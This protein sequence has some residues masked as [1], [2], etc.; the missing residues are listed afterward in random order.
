MVVNDVYTAL[1]LWQR[2]RCFIIQLGTSIDAPPK[3]ISIATDV[4]LVWMTP[5][6][7][8]TV[9]L[10]W[11]SG[12][13]ASMGPGLARGLG[14]GVSEESFSILLKTLREVENLC[15]K[16]SKCGLLH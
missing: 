15:L 2:S 16:G 13:R 9:R 11:F 12:E 14:R 8:P 1:C 10:P 6:P 7:I 4:N 5:P 3:T